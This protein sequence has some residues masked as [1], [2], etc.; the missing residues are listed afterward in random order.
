[1]SPLGEFSSE[2]CHKIW[3]GE[4]RMVWLSD[5]GN[6]FEDVNT[7]SDTIHEHNRQQDGQTDGQ[8]DRHRATA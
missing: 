5:P 3:Y 1:M 7:C 8:T 4:I 6:K 2:C